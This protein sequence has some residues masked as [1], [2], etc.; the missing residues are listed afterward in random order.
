[1]GLQLKRINRENGVHCQ[2]L[3]FHCVLDGLEIN[4]PVE[5]DKLKSRFKSESGDYRGL[6][7]TL[8]ALYQI[9]QG[10]RLEHLQLYIA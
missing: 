3:I 6:L 9:E 5:L 10:R 4:L 7:L 2:H 8:F 1:M